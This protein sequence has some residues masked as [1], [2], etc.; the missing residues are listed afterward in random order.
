MT[1][2][3]IIE[4]VSAHSGLDQP[5]ARRVC[6]AVVEVLGSCLPDPGKVARWLPPALGES[7]ARGRPGS[8]S[9]VDDFYQE[10]GRALGLA[11]GPSLEQAQSVCAA[12]AEGLDDEARE[13]LA[14]H[15]PGDVAA[16]LVPAP[17]PATPERPVHVGS[18]RGLA[19]GRPGS[20]HPVSTSPPRRAHRDSVTR[21]VPHQES[22]LSTGHVSIEE[23]EDT[24]AGGRPGSDRPLSGD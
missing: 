23:D 16:L 17:R 20:E 21:E 12:L 1:M 11:P 22:K 10:V 2:E 4:R 14:G 8:I 15:L 9:G 24:L 7:L 3:Q 5:R 6:H 19:V 18:G 13:M